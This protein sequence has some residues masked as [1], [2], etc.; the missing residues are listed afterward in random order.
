MFKLRP[1]QERISD[2]CVDKIIDYGICYLQLEVRVGKS[3]ISLEAAR[4]LGANNV[5]FITKK[6]AISSIQ[7]DYITAGHTF[8]ITII[9][10]ESLHKV[11]G[12]FDIII[13]DEH[14]RNG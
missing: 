10:N 1:Y 9:N 11:T 3:H 14:H 12:D 6:K 13:S 4:K 5:L 8:N 7:D 2:E